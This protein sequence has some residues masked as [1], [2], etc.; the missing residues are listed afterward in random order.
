M[1]GLFNPGNTISNQ[2]KNGMMGS[3][4]L[5]YEEINMSQSISTFTTGSRTAGATLSAAVTTQGAT[6]IAITGGGNGLT[7]LTG[8]VFTIA[9]VNAVNPQ[10]RQSTGS[11]FQFVATAD[12]TL[13][14]AGAGNIT[15]VAIYDK[16]QA[17]ATVD[18]LPG[19][20]AAVT[21]QGAAST[22]YPQNLIYHKDAIIFATADLVLH[23]T[24]KCS[25]MVHNGI[26][27][28]YWEASDIV[29]DKKY[30]R[31]DVLY[32]YTCIRPEMAVRLWG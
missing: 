25:R 32:G 6:T 5:G 24:G 20:G 2:F 8:D 3:G 9:A 14:G 1:K 13:S 12:V 19:N 29:N 31:L 23:D 28:R 15:V 4:V 30:V 26:S 27:M 21:W 22:V 18:V 16:A 7:V 10:T 17:L 11:L